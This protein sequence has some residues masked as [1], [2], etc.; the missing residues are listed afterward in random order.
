[1]QK[2]EQVIGAAG[3]G[4][5]AGGTSV[6]RLFPTERQHP[7]GLAAGALD[8]AF[9]SRLP[10]RAAPVLVASLPA[11]ID[12]RDHGGDWTTPIR[13][14][15][16]CGSCVAFA[17]LGAVESRLEIYHNDPNETPDLSEQ[18]L[19]FC[20]GGDCEYGW[21]PS[22]AMSFTRD[23]G[24]VD[25]TCDPYDANDHTC[26]LCT[27]W[28]IRATRIHCWYY[29]YG[30]D[31]VKYYLANYGPVEATMAVY[32]DFDSYTGGVYY[33]SEGEYRGGH[34][35]T[36]VGYDDDG[37][38]WIAKNSWGTDWGESGWFRAAY[39]DVIY[40]SAYVPVFDEVPPGKASNVRPDSWS[41]P[42]TNDTTPSFRW[43]S[44]TDDADGCGIQG[45]YVAVD[46]W[47]PEGTGGNDWWVGS[48][49]YSTVPHALADGEHIFAVTAVDVGNN[50]NPTD[51]D[52]PSDA[53][54]YTF[55]VDTSSPQSRVVSLPSESEATFTV[56]WFGSD[57]TSG[58]ASY[59][60]QVR[61]GGGLWWDWKTNTADSSA[62]FSG[63]PGH[64]YCFRS[65]ARDRAGNVE[66][67]F[68]SPDA[69]TMVR[70]FALF[71][72]LVDYGL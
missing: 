42:Y 26:S 68:S 49:I 15:S 6:S 39:G 27:D 46:D 52:H 9:L 61:D 51:T 34:A 16:D 20:G 35:I 58:I 33:H 45:Y 18:H 67:W 8:P 48:V 14:Q 63:T 40:D 65:R 69:C 24:V 38:Y 54:Y 57:A 36:L 31:D 71:L 23:I 1:V 50:P 7:L 19:F 11:S 28:Q 43:D 60:V 17:T 13:D 21:Y 29:V 47:T 66:S 32:T 70:G 59:D 25:E 56:S 64:T 72:P 62:T 44:A 41:G 3:G 55:Y 30:R 12:W 10:A 4:W 53:P 2:L 37:G 22:A 5:V